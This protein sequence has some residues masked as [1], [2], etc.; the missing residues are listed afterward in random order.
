[1]LFWIVYVVVAVVVVGGDDRAGG[2]VCLFIFQCEVCGFCC[3]VFV[4]VVVV[5]LRG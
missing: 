4:F 1:M 2:F 5:Y 3:C